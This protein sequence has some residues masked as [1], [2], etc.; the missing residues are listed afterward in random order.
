MEYVIIV[1][2]VLFIGLLYFEIKLVVRTAE[3]MPE[4]GIWNYDE[5][6]KTMRIKYFGE[7]P[8]KIGDVESLDHAKNIIEGHNVK[9]VGKN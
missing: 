1:L 9:Y 4:E 6:T 3:E 7:S 8:L 5:R 2:I